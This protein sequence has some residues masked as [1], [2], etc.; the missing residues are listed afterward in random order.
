MRPPVRFFDFVEATSHMTHL[1]FRLPDEIAER[2]QK[3]ANRT[4]RTKTH[5]ITEAICEYL[6]DVEEH[7]VLDRR[8][9]ELQSGKIKS[10]T[11]DDLITKYGV[12]A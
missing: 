9:K 12:D 10:L 1:S 8:L 11:L 7:E 4:G 3:L 5:Y 2:L 6:E